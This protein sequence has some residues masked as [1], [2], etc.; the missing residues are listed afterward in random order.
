MSGTEYPGQQQ[1]DTESSDFNTLQFIIKRALGKTSTATLVQVKKVTTTGL[2]A[3]VGQ[4]DV[5]PLVN[6]QDGLGTNYKHQ[7]VHNLPYFRLQGGAEK[8]IILDPK[9]GDIGVAVFADRDI[10]AVK[11][12]KAQAQ[13]GSYRRFDMADGLFFPCFLG[14]KPTC[15]LR[16]ADNDDI[17]ASPDDQNVFV[18][19]QKDQTI[20]MTVDNGNTA[21]TMT[22]GQIELKVGGSKL[23]ITASLIQLLA[24]LIELN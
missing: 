18:K 7:M 3:A 6:L 2:V 5:L 8:A 9:V 16:F 10:S 15:Y 12:N 11:K 24:S 13:P 1:L 19:I 22:A 21:L 23:T 20:S 4:V 14:G 17:I